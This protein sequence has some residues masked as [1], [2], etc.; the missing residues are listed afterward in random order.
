MFRNSFHHLSKCFGG[1][2]LAMAEP[3]AVIDEIIHNPHKLVA[4]RGGGDKLWCCDNTR[5][6]V[7]SEHY[8]LLHPS[9]FQPRRGL[10]TSTYLTFAGGSQTLCRPKSLLHM[11]ISKNR[12]LRGKTFVFSSLEET[13]KNKK[14][15]TPRVHTYVRHGRRILLSFT[16]LVFMTKGPL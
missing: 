6:E 1:R 14:T 15:H 16:S 4:I 9:F 5:L 10:P 11:L 13:K 2:T 12:H 8:F 7:V 3:I